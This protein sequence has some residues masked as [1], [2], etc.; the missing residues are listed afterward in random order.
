MTKIA[1]VYHKRLSS[2]DRSHCRDSKR[3]MDVHFLPMKPIGYQNSISELATLMMHPSISNHIIK[4]H[5]TSAQQLD[6]STNK[7]KSYQLDL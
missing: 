2:E 3:N 1:L 6:I 4:E 5:L 7:T